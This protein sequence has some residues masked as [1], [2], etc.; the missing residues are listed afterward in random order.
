MWRNENYVGDED[1]VVEHVQQTAMED[2]IDTETKEASRSIKKMHSVKVPRLYKEASKALHNIELNG[3]G[4]K[5]A[6]YSIK[7]PVSNQ[8]R[9]AG[10]KKRFNLTDQ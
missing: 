8:S 10:N 6:V 2:T 1:G 3:E 9:L 4:L 7:H 5:T